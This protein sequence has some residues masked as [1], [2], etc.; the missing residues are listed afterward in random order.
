MR[1][2]SPA[3][4]SVVTYESICMPLEPTLTR[5]TEIVGIQ[6]LRG[7]AALLVLIVHSDHMLRQEKYFGYSYLGEFSNGGNL[8]VDLFFVIS[9]FIMFHITDGFSMATDSNQFLRRRFLRIVPFMWLCIISTYVLRSAVRGGIDPLPFVRAFFLW[10]VGDIDP[11]PVWT[12][13]HELFFYICAYLCLAFRRGYLILWAFLLFPI[14][15]FFFRS[16]FAFLD[17]E[18]VS[19]FFHLQ[20]NTSFAMGVFLGWLYRQRAVWHGPRIGT[21]AVLATP[22]ILLCFE[23]Y[24]TPMTVAPSMNAPNFGES[25]TSRQALTATAWSDANL[26]GS[27]AKCILTTLVCGCLVYGSLECIAG[28]TWANRIGL[29]LGNASYSI[30]L[31]HEIIISFTGIVF[32]KLKLL[33]LAAVACVSSILIALVFGVFVHFV[34]EKPLIQVLRKWSA[35]EW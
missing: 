7:I 35:R 23:Y 20:A 5:K 28:K 4:L 8:G 25:A 19:N 21:I 30:Y 15:I 32:V 12:L 22:I 9:G 17:N 27:A 26:L 18:L 24:V 16:K 34:I 1:W 6:Y 31:T 3:D 14:P 33:E 13:R 10:P 2:A 11:N 29:T